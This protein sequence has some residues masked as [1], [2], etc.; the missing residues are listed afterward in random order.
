MWFFTEEEKQIKELCADFARRE[1]AP[2]AEKH[3]TEESFNIEA[4]RK[5]GELGVLGITADPKYG[6]AGMGAVAA[7]IVMEEFGKACASSTLS[8][9]AHSILCVNNIQNNASEEQK[10][11]YLPKLIS[12][13]HIGCMGMSE[14][15]Y[16]SDAVGIQTKAEKKDDHY[17]LNGTKMW[18]TNAEYADVAYVY[19]RTGKERKNLST[20][21]VEKGAEGFSIGKPIHKM[22]MR[23]S[24]TGE[25][26]FD[27][28]KVP[29]SALVGN[30]GDSIYHMMKNLE[31]ER[32]TIA[33]ISLGI[34][35]ACVDQCVKYAGEREQFGKSL[36][37]YQMIQKMIAEMA[38]ET[39]MM[40]RFLY[41]VAKE[42]DDGKKGPMVAAQ[43]KLQIPKMATKIAL[44]AIQLHGGYG[45][46]REFPVERM[47]RDNKLN[48][49][50]AGTN[51][52]MIM[53]I[54]KELLS[55]SKTAN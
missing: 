5:M 36:G 15:E 8:Y 4:F 17:L 55:L 31:L 43:V 16:G 53:I 42:Y 50:G 40:R 33:G 1:L 54:A 9:L 41:T 48:E 19:T 30:E 26:V 29:H 38:T 46:S 24:P 10:E 44:D 49:I 37:N 21:I 47:M 35:Q 18:I 11:K 27:N 39:E 51:E 12:G 23:A 20:F 52:V 7:T 22:G 13:E 14:P 6:G 45:Y 32:I 3:D 25:L 34:A 28:C 2:V